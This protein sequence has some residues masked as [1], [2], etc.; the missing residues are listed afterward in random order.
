MSAYMVDREH[1]IFLVKAA[2]SR[3]MAQH[4]GGSIRWYYNGTSKKLS[5]C[6]DI[7]K[8]VEV[9]QMLWDENK[10]SINARYHDT[11]DNPDNMPGAIGEDYIIRPEDFRLHWFDYDPVQVMKAIHCYEYQSCEHKE[12]KDSE[13]II[14]IRRLENKAIS[15]L[16]GY[17][18]AK[19]GNPQ[20]GY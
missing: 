3:H 19:W 1:I 10:K 4:D 13:A 15:A 7:E 8:L 16:P 14:F 18:E 6:E 17:D 5:C 11:V 12:W 2:V 9:A 20:T